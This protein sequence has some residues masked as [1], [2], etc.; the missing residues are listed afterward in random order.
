MAKTLRGRIYLVHHH[1]GSLHLLEQY[2]REYAVIREGLL[3]YPGRLFLA[4]DHIRALIALGKLAEAD[5]SVES[6][7]TLA[8]DQRSSALWVGA[9]SVHEL[10][11]HS[12]T[13]EATALGERLLRRM[14]ALPRLEGDSPRVWLERRGR[15]EL[16]A[17]TRQWAALESGAGDVLRESP[18]SIIGL[19]MRGVALAMQGKRAQALGV[20]SVLAAATTPEQLADLCY[21]ALPGACRRV[22]R[23]Y[24]AAALGDKARAVSLLDYRSFN[25]NFAH[26]DM[27]GEWLRDFPPFQEYI[28]PRG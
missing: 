19:R 3:Q 26:Y 10:R 23:A 5:R 22:A 8:P 24:I 18:R 2:E 13:A 14:S 9:N 27:I 4:T 21:G 1:A 7:F 6:L 20:D 25:D 17:A 28:K 11:W 12:H 15:L 16:L